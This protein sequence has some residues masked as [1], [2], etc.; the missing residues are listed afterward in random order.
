MVW[1]SCGFTVQSIVVSAMDA[2]KP[3]FG[4]LSSRQNDCLS[5]FIRFCGVVGSNFGEPKVIRSHSLKLLST[6]LECDANNPSVLELDMFG[7]LVSLTYSLPSLFNGEGPAPLPSCNVQDNHILS[8]MFLAHITQLLFSIT[9]A[10]PINTQPEFTFSPP[11]KEC[12]PLL[13][14]VDV[15]LTA[16]NPGESGGLKCDLSNVD[17]LAL[18]QVI[19]EKYKIIAKI[20]DS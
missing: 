20:P 3:L 12:L 6:V 7:L 9:P 1:Q 11:A 14:L 4:N 19:M 15:V 16:F 10:F 5:A 8:L 2:D 18:W 13:D 17:P